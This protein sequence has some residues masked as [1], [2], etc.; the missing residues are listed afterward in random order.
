LG[1]TRCLETMEDVFGQVD[2]KSAL[3]IAGLAMHRAEKRC[4]DLLCRK[5]SVAASCG[6]VGDP[7]YNSNKLYVRTIKQSSLHWLQ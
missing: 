2:G 1:G 7:A 5:P 3:A 4:Q 6:D